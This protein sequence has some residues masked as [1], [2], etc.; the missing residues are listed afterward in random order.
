MRMRF[1]NNNWSQQPS[2]TTTAVFLKHEPQRSE[3]KYLM[4]QKNNS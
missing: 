4:S 1:K 2:L 3:A